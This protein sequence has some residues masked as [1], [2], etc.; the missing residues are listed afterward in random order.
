M[1]RDLRQERATP[2][3]FALDEERTFL[4][5]SQVYLEDG[6]LHTPLD[7][8]RKGAEL[9][10]LKMGLYAAVG[11]RRGDPWL[12]ALARHWPEDDETKLHTKIE[13]LVIYY[14]AAVIRHGRKAVLAQRPDF[15]SE[16]GDSFSV[17]MAVP[18][19]HA[20][21]SGVEAAFRHCLNRAW[22]S[23]E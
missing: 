13:A 11:D 15:D 14:L 8:Q 4:L 22:R 7:G 16:I 9:G 2:V 20:Q 23:C 6:T 21:E 12:L 18:I 10:C 17:N 19:A 1:L 3:A 5:P